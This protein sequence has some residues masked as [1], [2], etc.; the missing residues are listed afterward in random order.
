VASQPLAVNVIFGARLSL[1]WVRTVRKISFLETFPM[2]F[3]TSFSDS[4]NSFFHPRRFRA[5]RAA[6]LGLS[7]RI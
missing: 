7:L 3:A 6:L 1:R 5:S 4:R 2:F